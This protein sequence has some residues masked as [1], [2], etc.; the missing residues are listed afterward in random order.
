M[1]WNYSKIEAEGKADIEEKVLKIKKGEVKKTEIYK[2]L[3]DYITEEGNKLTC[4][5][6]LTEKINFMMRNVMSWGA[7]RV[8]HSDPE[9]GIN[10]KTQSLSNAKT[11]KL[12]IKRTL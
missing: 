12:F 4:I 9:H 7:E 8:T 3:G 2:Y 5:E 11:V 10:V 6:K 1:E